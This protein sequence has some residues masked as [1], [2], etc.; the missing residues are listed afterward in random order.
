MATGND[1]PAGIPT[2]G[3]EASFTL[4]VFEKHARVG[5]VSLER[6]RGVKLRHKTPLFRM[7]VTQK[8][9]GRGFGKSLLQGALSRTRD[10]DDLRYTHLTALEQN[11]RVR[12]LYRSLGFS[13]F[14]MA[15]EAVRMD[16]NYVVEVKV[17]RFLKG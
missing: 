4:G 9:A 8:S 13:D 2:R 5:I 1:V 6:D 14:V 7:F 17:M 3:E 10:I 12:A 16:P 15:P 11:Q